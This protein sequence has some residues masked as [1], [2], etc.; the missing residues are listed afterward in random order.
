MAR[1]PAMRNLL[2]GGRSFDRRPLHRPA[3]PLS[4]V[5]CEDGKLTPSYL[6]ALCVHMR[7]NSAAVSIPPNQ[8]SAPISVVQFAAERWRADRDYDQ[9]FCVIDRNGHESYQ[10]ALQAATQYAAHPES[11]IPM[12][13]LVSVPC[14]EYWLLL[15]F[16]RTTRP[17]RNC[18][19]VVDRLR[20]YVPGY[21]KGAENIIDIALPRTEQALQNA[22]WVRR[23]QRSARSTNPLTELDLLVDYLQGLRT[24]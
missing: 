2:R 20:R 12:R 16:E 6:R 10:R 14:F 3:R 17:M 11:P 13:A 4:L 24:A 19:E 1:R 23:Q 21:E 22:R 5:V 9:V 18:A 7:V 15:H 8:G